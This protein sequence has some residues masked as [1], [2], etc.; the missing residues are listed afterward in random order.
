MA[1]DLICSAA[2]LVIAISYYLLAS[3]IGRSALSDEV[4]PGGLPMLY[5]TILALLAVV[6][7]MT[8]VARTKLGRAA[9]ETAVARIESLGPLLY[10]AAGTFAIGVGYL[11]IAPFAGYFLALLMV[12][13]ATAMHFG[14]RASARLA[15]VS[16]AGATAFW[17]LFVALLGIPM[18]TLWS[19]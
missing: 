4:G 12:I 19:P 3:G 14:E 6:L 2:L 13:A 8:T 15:L 7:A 17:L 11:L 18:P 10:R 16:L 1:R 9:A 5:A